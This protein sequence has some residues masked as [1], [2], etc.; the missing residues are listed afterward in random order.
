MLCGTEERKKERIGTLRL[1][2]A[3]IYND[4]RLK[5]GGR[6]ISTS[7][8]QSMMKLAKRWETDVW[9]SGLVCPEPA[10]LGVSSLSCLGG[11]GQSGESTTIPQCMPSQ[12]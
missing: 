2:A 1:E 6:G 9:T 8:L 5:V 3:E 4:S 10:L 7:N 11:C 12:A